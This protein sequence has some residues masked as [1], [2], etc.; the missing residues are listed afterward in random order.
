MRTIKYTTQF[1]RDYKREKK[2]NYHKNLDRNLL[3]TVE[4]LAA[5][6]PLPPRRYD[7]ALTGNWN[8][9][10]YQRFRGILDFGANW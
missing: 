10:N 7:H 4:L 9:H 6:K 2:S 3:D 5:D 8:D 1:K